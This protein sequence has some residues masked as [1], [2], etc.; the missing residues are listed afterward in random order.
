MHQNVDL[1]MGYS[2][3][4]G[5]GAIVFKIIVRSYSGYHILGNLS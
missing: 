5:F 2:I 1:K 3:E 4:L